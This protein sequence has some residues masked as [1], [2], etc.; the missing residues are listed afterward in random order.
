MRTPGL[1]HATTGCQGAGSGESAVDQTLPK[2]QFSERKQPFPACR[3]AH[4]E[5]RARNVIVLHSTGGPSHINVFG[6]KPQRANCDAEAAPEEF[7]TGTGFGFM[8][9]QP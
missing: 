1:L 9:V 4:F 6:P 5:P 2:I 3:S 7:A 8:W